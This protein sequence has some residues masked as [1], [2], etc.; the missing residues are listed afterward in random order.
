MKAFLIQESKAWEPLQKVLKGMTFAYEIIISLIPSSTKPVFP[1]GRK[2][3]FAT[4]VEIGII[5]LLQ[6]IAGRSTTPI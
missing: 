1:A 5:E 3:N 4:A 2:K 6:I